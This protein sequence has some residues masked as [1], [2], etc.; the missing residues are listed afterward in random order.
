MSRCALPGCGAIGPRGYACTEHDYGYHI[1]RGT[2]PGS[3]A[4]EWPLQGEDARAYWDARYPRTVREIDRERYWELLEVLPPERWHT[5]N[6]F[7]SFNLMEHSYGETA[8]IV[9]Q[10]HNSGRYFEYH[11]PVRSTPEARARY[12]M[13]HLAQE[14][15]P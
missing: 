8:L 15:T 11:G 1:A 2:E 9:V 13:E 7:E 10:D 14:V 3:F 6:G 4:E 12:V 5:W